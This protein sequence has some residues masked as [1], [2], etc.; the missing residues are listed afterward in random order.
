M[1]RCGT[2]IFDLGGAYRQ[3]TLSYAHSLVFIV[4]LCL[5]IEFIIIVNLSQDEVHRFSVWYVQRHFLCYISW[6]RTIST[7]CVLM[8]LTVGM[9]TAEECQDDILARVKFLANFTKCAIKKPTEICKVL[10]NQKPSCVTDA[11]WSS[12]QK[13]SDIIASVKNLIARVEC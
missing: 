12:F 9:V 3:V 8:M 4:T 1:L 11:A 13:C 5:V 7:I 6:V 2:S 10:Q